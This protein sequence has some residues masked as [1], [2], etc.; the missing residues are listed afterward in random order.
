MNK[1]IDLCRG[2]G[3]VPGMYY[4]VS[5]FG[6]SQYITKEMAEKERITRY[7]KARKEIEIQKNT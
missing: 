5:G 4:I 6:K 3:F 7:E 1:I 2:G